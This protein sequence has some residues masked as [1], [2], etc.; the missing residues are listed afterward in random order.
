[1]KI[2]WPLLIAAV[3][4]TSC[5]TGVGPSAVT[6]GT[7]M[8]YQAEN[9]DWW[10]ENAPQDASQNFA[11]P[12]PQGGSQPPPAFIPGPTFTNTSPTPA[13]RP[14]GIADPNNPGYDT[15]GYL[16]N[17]T[18]DPNA[19]P[20]GHV[21][22]NAPQPPSG[23]PS[24]GP[25]W[26]GPIDPF[27]YNP[28]GSGYPTFTPPPL[29]AELQKPW[30]LPSAADV[31]AM[32]GYQERFNM[33]L[34]ARDRSAA[35]HGTILNGGTQKALARYGQDYAT[36]AY[37]DLTNQSLQQRQQA[38]SDYLNL[39]YGPAWQQNQSAVNQY[40]QLYNQ[41]RDLV[42]SN[43]LAQ[44]DYWQ[45]QMDLLNAGLGAA[46]AGAVGTGGQV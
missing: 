5:G 23:G 42:G 12:P 40:G 32:P 37:N 16:L 39:A 4:N 10:L 30:E 14:T 15:A 45:Q 38:A 6:K 26:G 24:G 13:S 28:T 19:G 33:G 29:P 18:F 25:T 20:F 11:A 8:A 46:K 22:P 9:Q 34:N 1:M 2:L 27:Q 7:P 31:Q 21:T 17:S 44:N 36:N 43:R 41:Y 35:A 3:V